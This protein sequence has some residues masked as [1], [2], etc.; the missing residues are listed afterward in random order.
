M[1]VLGG[2]HL[3]FVASA[4]VC[5]QRV[6]RLSLQSCDIVTLGVRILKGCP[7]GVCPAR[8]ICIQFSMGS[9]KHHP[10]KMLYHYF[11]KSRVP[12]PLR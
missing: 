5:L 6:L 7:I 10:P 8:V 1:K 9:Q 11:V 3:L 12:G 2:L 4:D